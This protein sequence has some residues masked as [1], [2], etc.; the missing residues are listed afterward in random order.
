LQEKPKK[1]SQFLDKMKK[2][3]AEEAERAKK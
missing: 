2:E 3:M 1:S